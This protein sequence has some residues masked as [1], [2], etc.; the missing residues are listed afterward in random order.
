MLLSRAWSHQIWLHAKNASTHNQYITYFAGSPWWPHA[1]I[2][3]V[4]KH[5]KRLQL[6]SLGVEPH[7][8][9]PRHQHEENRVAETKVHHFWAH[10]CIQ[11]SDALGF[12][13][14]CSLLEE[15]YRTQ[16]LELARCFSRRIEGSRNRFFLHNG[17]HHVSPTIEA[18]ADDA[19]H[20]ATYDIEGHGIV[21]TDS[22]QTIFAKI[23]RSESGSCEQDLPKLHAEVTAVQASEYTSRLDEMP[24]NISRSIELA[25]AVQLLCELDVFH[26]GNRPHFRKNGNN[27]CSTRCDKV[28][29]PS[30]LQELVL[31]HWLHPKLDTT[32]QRRPENF[33]C[34]TLFHEAN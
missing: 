32:G 10:T 33:N 29:R 8:F 17:A 24:R 14:S 21:E 3:K 4:G 23:N 16:W 6:D 15:W 27:T 1:I 7:F 30:I 34:H 31:C 12:H 20:E 2:A 26:G 22:T 28:I 25:L 18:D 13:K 11:S 19:R 9:K 5:I